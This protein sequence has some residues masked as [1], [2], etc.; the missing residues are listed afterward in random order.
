MSAPNLRPGERRG[1]V[2]VRDNDAIVES[3]PELRKELTDV[4]ELSANA[5]DHEIILF[6]LPVL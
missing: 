1:D 4:A 2:V 5:C 6:K 3:E